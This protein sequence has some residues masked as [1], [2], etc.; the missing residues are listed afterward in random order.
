MVAEL[1]AVRDLEIEI[2]YGV[3]SFVGSSPGDLAD[4]STE[5]LFASVFVV[6]DGAG[7]L[8]IFRCGRSEHDVSVRVEVWSE[9]PPPLS[10]NRWTA[11]EEEHATFDLARNSVGRCGLRIG[12]GL[13][14]L[15]A[16][17]SPLPM[18]EGAYHVHAR[19]VGRAVARAQWKLGDAPLESWLIRLWPVAH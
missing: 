18:E 7:P 9:A 12:L 4:W 10:D 16:D 15:D 3:F 6:A 1:L 8:I 2:H 13:G 19:V 14:E 17:A 5:K 11:A